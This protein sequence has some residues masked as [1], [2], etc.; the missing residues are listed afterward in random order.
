MSQCLTSFVL[1]IVAMMPTWAQSAHQARP[2]SI[3]YVEG[4]ASIGTQLLGANSPGSVELEKGQSLTTQAGKVEVLL[5]PGVFLRIA[6]NSSVRMISPELA[7]TEVAIK[8]GRPAVEVLDI[9][10]ENYI[11]I[12]LNDSNTRLLN[13]GLY[14]FDAAN[15]QIR[16]FKGKA[17]VFA[18]DK[19]VT[20]T[21]QHELTL[22]TSGKL[23]AQ[24]FDTRK[25]EDEFFRWSALRSGYLSE[26]SADEA[27][28]YI[29][30]GSG[31]YGPGWYGPSWYGPSWYGPGWYWD[32]NFFVYTFLPAAGVFYS[33][34]GW[35]F[36]SPIFIYRTPFFYYGFYGHGPHRFDDFHSPYG[37]G[38]EPPGGFHGGGFHGLAAPERGRR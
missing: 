33:P 28:V 36:Y 8:S 1:L 34:F 18:D 30:A 7:N 6:D 22:N 25:Y 16:V 9:H 31:W 15:D 4:A 20:L 5:T 38:F 14:E 29:G 35:G 11:R 19:K 26:A 37:H 27:R 23:K 10:K 2:G 3:N 13:K 21:S 32:P 12:D 17:T 24:N